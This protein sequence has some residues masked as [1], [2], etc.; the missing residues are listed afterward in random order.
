MFCAVVSRLCMTFFFSVRGCCL[1]LHIVGGTTA[2]G[3][4]EGCPRSVSTNS[5]GMLTDFSM[6]PLACCFQVCCWSA[7]YSQQGQIQQK[8]INRNDQND[9]ECVSVFQSGNCKGSGYV[10]WTVSLFLIGL[11]TV[12]SLNP[13]S[14]SSGYS[15]N[16]RL[17]STYVV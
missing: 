16:E 15:S 5:C 6:V 13:V 1:V 9:A 7:V 17:V 8:R 3:E 4:R 2:L 12:H 10:S 14:S 11:L